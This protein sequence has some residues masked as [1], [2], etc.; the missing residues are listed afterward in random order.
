MGVSVLLALVL[1]LGAVALGV[2]LG[3]AAA[4]EHGDKEVVAE[5][6]ATGV[7]GDLEVNNDN[8]DNPT[9]SLPAPKEVDQ[10]IAINGEIYADG[11][12]RTTEVAFPTLGEDILGLPITVDIDAPEPFE[13]AID[14][15]QGQLYLNGTLRIVIGDG[16]AQINVTANLT[17]GQSNGLTGDASG[18]DTESAN[19]TLVNNEYTINQ[20][21][22]SAAAD[23]FLDLPSPQPGRNWFSLD[24]RMEIESETGTVEGTVR[25]PEG[26]PVESVTVTTGVGTGQTTTASDGSFQLDAPA[27]PNSVIATPD[28]EELV[29]T[30]EPVT[31][32]PDETITAD[33][34]LL[35]KLFEPI[36]VLA[37][38]GNAG[39]TIQM[40]GLFRNA[41]DETGTR[42]VIL[43]VADESVT[44]TR[45]LEPNG[46]QTINY[47]WE[48]DSDDAGDHEVVLEVDDQTVSRSLSLQGPDL[49]VSVATSNVAPGETLTVE[50][51]VKNEGTVSGAQDV[52]ISVAD[53][54][55]TETVQLGPGGETTVTLTWE[56]GS[57]DAGEYEAT[58]ETGG[59]TVTESVRVREAVSQDVGDEVDFIA[60]STGG[61][62]AYDYDSFSEA[63][64]QGL[65][66]PDINAGEDPI[67]I[68][69]KINEEEGTWEST[70]T[71]FPNITQ[72]GIQGTVRAPNGLQGEVDREKGLL[73]ATGQYWVLIEGDQGTSF[74]FNMTMRTNESG[75]IT[76]D[77]KYEE[78]NDTFANI[79]FVGNEF[80]VREQTDDPV[81]DSTL[82]LPS[83]TPGRNY[84]ELG[85]EVN[86]D[87][88][89]TDI[90]DQEE[91]NETAAETEANGTLFATLGQ[92][93]GGVGIVA[94][95][96][97]VLSGLYARVGRGGADG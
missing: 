14:R 30:G 86:F 24:L 17:T 13:G 73:T 54:S 62:M 50:A 91:I 49:N 28:S 97:F 19:L 40:T 89:D 68:A 38:D 18:L 9:A 2:G 95:L 83:P 33:V 63:E 27:G 65:D 61:Y 21:T 26:E 16:S 4:D 42:D 32:L 20:T 84:M 39:D 36:T 44:T 82:K 85:F 51:T 7:G 76:E 94:G 57:D 5:F 75:E 46:V 1:A 35:P 96:L 43:S 47:N 41:G 52:T 31:I 23:S 53:E 93:L 15:E 3:P 11:T 6:N 71:F 77:G 87:P 88:E 37:S 45:T 74:R 60:R 29:T 66:F 48:T 78:V 25:S 59:Q 34:Q 92:G 58:A 79:N 10:P 56:T 69:G 80:A 90:R 81:V 64:G 55:T 67:V 70:Q 8:A 72:E 12:V 22:G